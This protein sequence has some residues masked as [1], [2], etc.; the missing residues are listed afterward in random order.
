MTAPAIILGTFADLK[1]VKTRS[2]VQIVV[3]V[4]IEQGKQVVDAFG[5]PQPGA[6]IP[7]AVTRFRDDKK[8]QEPEQKPKRPGTRFADMPP[9]QQA[10]MLCND[11][12]FQTWACKLKPCLLTA[13]NRILR[14]CGIASRKELD[15]DRNAHIF[16]G[17]MLSKFHANT[18]RTAEERG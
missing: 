6:E 2:V 4:P 11:P 16:W 3:E 18:G 15:S 5:F 14:E 7:V 10:G 12:V 8:P 9:S 13:R 17:E 1:T